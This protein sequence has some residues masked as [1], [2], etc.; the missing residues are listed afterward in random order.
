MRITLT[1]TA[2]LRDEQGMKGG[3]YR[4]GIT[5][6]PSGPWDLLSTSNHG[7]QGPAMGHAHRGCSFSVGVRT[8]K[9]SPGLSS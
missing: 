4:A 6:W 2:R 9:L 1:V 8:G 3:P 5:L 7:D